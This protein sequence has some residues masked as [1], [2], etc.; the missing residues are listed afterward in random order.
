MPE[1]F[2]RYMNLC[3][4]VEVMNALQISLGELEYAPIKEWEKI[5]DKVYAPGKWTIKDLL[6]HIIDC[7][8]VFS[9]RALAFAR[10]E[11]S[12]QSFDEDNYAIL[13]KANE[14]SLASLMEEALTLRRS[15]IQLFASFTEE[16]LC[17]SGQG[18]TGLFSV[19]DIGFI[20]AGHQR[21]HFKVIAE[22][23]L[24]LV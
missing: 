3:D 11:K 5:G 22:R 24:P 7:E 9:Y 2:D 1:Y 8:R 16:T 18:F 13:A 14:R 19:R 4:D 21:W 15:S 12:V 17:R 23:Y 6:Q 10:G 20:L